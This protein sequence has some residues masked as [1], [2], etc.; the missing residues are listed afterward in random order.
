MT[1][2]DTTPKSGRSRKTSRSRKV[3]PPQSPPEWESRHANDG[4]GPLAD[5]ASDLPDRAAA[6]QQGTPGESA[7][8]HGSGF[9]E[10]A[11]A[12]HPTFPDQA[13]GSEGAGRHPRQAA[14]RERAY[15][16][17][18]REGRPEGGHERHWMQAEREL[19]DERG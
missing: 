10:T 13:G 9:Q 3:A 12:V 15:Q 17:W 11:D 2:D 6:L 5:N 19:R 4:R 7:P 18:E 1:E 8:V 16:I 14:V